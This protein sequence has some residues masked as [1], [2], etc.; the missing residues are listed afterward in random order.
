V[1]RRGETYLRLWSQSLDNEIAQ[2]VYK[3]KAFFLTLKHR[4]AYYNASDILKSGK[5]A[6]NVDLSLKNVFNLQ[7]SFLLTIT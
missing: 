3:E 5:I 7:N 4:L 6:K 1:N 2:C